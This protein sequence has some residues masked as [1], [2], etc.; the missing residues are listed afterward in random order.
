MNDFS[1]FIDEKERV[2]PENKVFDEI[3]DLFDKI[4][5]SLIDE[6]LKEKNYD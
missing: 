3:N 1:E 6:V 2:F 5:K 4:E